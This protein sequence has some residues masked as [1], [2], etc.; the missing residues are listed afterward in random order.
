MF[1]KL[2]TPTG[3]KEFK[4]QSIVKTDIEG[5]IEVELSPGGST[6][7]LP[8]DGNTLYVMNDAGDTIDTVRFPVRKELKAL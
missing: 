6:L 4:C 1:V 2:I 3:F 8:H 7:T 5:G